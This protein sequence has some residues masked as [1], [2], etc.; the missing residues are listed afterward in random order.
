MITSFA[1]FCLAVYVLVDDVLIAQAPLRPGPRPRCSDSEL[2]TMVLVGECRGWD[3]ETELIAAFGD[4]PDLFPVLP[5]RSRF[6]RRRRN[7]MGTI[8]RLRQDLLQHLD[9][10]VDRQC[11]IDRLPVPILGFHLVPRAP[12]TGAWRAAGAAFGWIKS[13]KQTIFGYKLHLLV[14]LNGVILD[15]VL[16]SANRDDLAVG[17]SLLA[18]HR[19]LTVLGDKGYVSA[20]ATAQLAQQADVRLLTVPRRNQR[21]QL[22]PVQVKLHNRWRHIIETV[23]SQLAGQ[24]QLETNRAKSFWGLCTRLYSKLTAHTIGLYL[25]RLFGADDCLQIKHLAFPN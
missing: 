12:A 20:P 23:T 22:A 6:N 4:Y 15:F 18:A 2:I 10:A 25:N 24:L 11:A 8:N 9:L 5:E 17:I 7:L 14:T 1:D 21:Q 19:G 13:K 3:Q 16:A